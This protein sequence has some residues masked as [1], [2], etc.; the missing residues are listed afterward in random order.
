M[1]PR[2]PWFITATSADVDWRLA[3]AA[4][5]VAAQAQEPPARVALIDLGAAATPV[6]GPVTRLEI[7][8]V[9]ELT[10]DEATRM[11][12]AVTRAH[13][14]TL[15]AAGPGL[16]MPAGR[17]GWTLADLAA[18]TGGTAVVV[19][20]P[21]PDAVNHTT[22]TLS[23][24]SGQGIGAS[25]VMIGEVDEEALPVTP[26]GRIPA[27]ATLPSADA[28][29]WFEPLFREPAPVE[30][31]PRPTVSGRKL[32]LGLVGVFLVM[33]LVV[34]GLAMWGGVETEAEL[35]SITVTSDDS[36]SGR[37][38]SGPDP[39]ISSEQVLPLPRDTA[40]TRPPGVTLPEQPQRATAADACPENVAGVT[41][42]RP[43]AATTARVEAAWR[44][45]EKWL[46][47]R[48]PTAAK[49]LRPPAAA[50]DVDAL[51]RQMS[52]AFPPD[53][54]ASLRRHDG[55]NG[56]GFSFPPFFEP[57]SLGGIRGDW[58]VSCEV[59][60]GQ[61]TTADWWHKQF[62]PFASAGDGGSLVVDQR[63]GGHGRV[64]EFYP[65]DGTTFDDWPA[66]FTALLEGT[67]SALE[68]GKAYAGHYTPKV[69]DGR[70]D[71]DIN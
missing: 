55:L 21:G 48:A 57:S 70:L 10:L 29:G 59:L 7:P 71:W 42:T 28:A 67:A 24:L 20:G 33:V 64:G 66:S 23:A 39:T 8:D 58:R 68:T 32:V 40:R 56:Y 6:P 34:C 46:A 63:P 3:A 2:G 30:A 13:G 52:V 26:A 9:A 17:D 25:V 16:L 41:P 22:L 44:R 4:L 5:V 37:W 15:T 35:H 54:V 1:N 38:D 50:A 36:L 53:L 69:A 43:D 19:T 27:D 60:A 14:L 61:N 47:A 31:E 51:Q 49:A 45:I 12:R 11:V 65:E 62:V 18:E